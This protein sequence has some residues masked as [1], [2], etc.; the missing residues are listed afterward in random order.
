MRE[1]RRGSEMSAVGFAPGTA[2]QCA[3][4]VELSLSCRYANSKPDNLTS[5]LLLRHW[6][7]LKLEHSS[8]NKLN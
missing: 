4:E 7:Q 3:S 8:D 5:C 6:F 2:A 1:I